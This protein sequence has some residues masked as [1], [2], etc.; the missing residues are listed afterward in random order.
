M[1]HA[2]LTQNDAS[3]STARVVSAFLGGSIG[4]A[5][6][7]P[8]ERRGRS[9][10]SRDLTPV[11][12]ST[13]RRW[14]KLSGGRF[15]PHSEL[16]EP[17][18]YS[19]DTQLTLALAR[20]I[21]FARHWWQDFCF[22]ELTSW[23]TYERGAGS[24]SKRAAQKFVAGEPPWLAK[25]E[26]RRKYFDAGG[27]GAAMRILPVVASCLVKS[28]TTTLSDLIAAASVP[29]HGHPRALLGASVY[30]FV[31]KTALTSTGTLSYGS[32]VEAALDSVEVWSQPPRLDLYWP[33]WQPAAEDHSNGTYGKMWARTTEEVVSLLK[34]AQ[35]GLSKGA[36][37]VDQQTLSELG[38]FSREV[39]GAGT[40]AAVA[41]IFL[42][43][44]YAAA[45]V[46]GVVR[47]AFAEG[48][49]TD[50]IASMTGALLGG[51][52]GGEW[53][54]G[55]TKSLQDAEYISKIAHSLSKG[56]EAECEVRDSVTQRDIDSFIE[57]LESRKP[58]IALLTP[59]RRN[60]VEV[61]AGP[62]T[63]RAPSLAAHSFSLKLSDGQT[64][65]VKK[66]RRVSA[67]RPVQSLDKGSRVVAVNVCLEVNNLNR[68]KEFYRDV[69]GFRQLKE[70]PRTVTFEGGFA[71]RER[72]GANFEL[73][74]VAVK[75]P[76]VLF[77][78]VNHA[79]ASW[80]ER[81]LRAGATNIE[82][83]RAHG[84]RRSF[85]CLDP[86]GNKLEFFEKKD[87]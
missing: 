86:D 51:A 25:N 36:L 23:T 1:I 34:I 64:I 6:G 50:T 8:N 75:Q 44:R 52:V 28:Q 68:S 9:T 49:D 11:D 48:A 65:H 16:I 76:I 74:L 4:D 82:E 5:L 33:N 63:T 62:V 60:V 42:A 13:F 37:A 55:L 38:C 71:I 27:N 47:A 17:G 81:L 22:V 19:D 14:T 26:D 39:S 61:K 83:I 85:A 78:E 73:A 66:L 20:S 59:D 57:N 45:P 79:L 7:W 53:I 31:L 21:I 87:E 24:A 70:A 67:S 35:S 80:H 84:H 29:T 15:Q 41:A 54:I 72:N 30:A 3:A 58:D 18:E 43:S 10:R 2:H 56:I 12:M 46:Q 77:V 40:I 32:L 69:I